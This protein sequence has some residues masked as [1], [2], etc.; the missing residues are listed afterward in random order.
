MRAR[1]SGVLRT[2]LRTRSGRVGLVLFS[3][4]VALVAIGPALSPYSSTAIGL[5]RPLSP[6]SSAHPLGTD[7]LGRDV[8]SRFLHGGGTLLVAPFVAVLIA[9]ALGGVLGLVA[10]ASRRAVDHAA[11]GLI[12]VLITIPAIMV[13][14]I[15]AAAFGASPLVLVLSVGFASAPRVALV[16]R[17]VARDALAQDYV[18]AARTRGESTPRILLREIGP[19][20]AGPVL[21]DASLRLTYAIGSIAAMAY[22]G[23]GAQPPSSDWGL[24]VAEG[25]VY[26]TTAPWVIAPAALAI[27]VTCVALT[28]LVDALASAF[29]GRLR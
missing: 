19:N 20:I 23:L 25:M 11:L 3:L 28:L 7:E 13:I 5:A 14:L 21:A 9:L 17:S 22:L 16:V 29:E 27:V 8:L 15:A 24:A 12:N 2:A 26:L 6:P 1:R 4:V 10:A 18:T